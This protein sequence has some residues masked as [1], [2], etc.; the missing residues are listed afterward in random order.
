MRRKESSKKKRFGK[1][2]TE[3]SPF[4]LDPEMTRRRFNQSQAN[5]RKKM[6]SSKAKRE[7]LFPLKVPKIKA[8]GSPAP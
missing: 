6:I 8:V 4:G 5:S 1:T 2:R 7:V 3:L